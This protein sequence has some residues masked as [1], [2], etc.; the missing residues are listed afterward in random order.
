MAKID[1]FAAQ[2]Q[3]FAA[4]CALMRTGFRGTCHGARYEA[5]VA[6]EK[7]KTDHEGRLYYVYTLEC[8]DI[9]WRQAALDEIQPFRA[10]DILLLR[11]K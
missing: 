5:R 2:K 8:D 11:N 7:I 9:Q 4:A 10:D 3:A 6:H 1:G